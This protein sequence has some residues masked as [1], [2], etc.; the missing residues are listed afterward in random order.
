MPLVPKRV[1]AT[2]SSAWWA[3]RC[4]G[5][6]PDT[7]IVHAGSSSMLGTTPA[8][9]RSAWSASSATQASAA[10]SIQ[11]IDGGGPAGRCGRTDTTT[12]RVAPAGSAICRQPADDEHQPGAD[13]AAPQLLSQLRHVRGGIV[14]GHDDVDAE[15][16]QPL[17]DAR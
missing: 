6:S 16:A 17:D 9:R 12:A 15:V 3:R 8:A 2:V 13:P 5:S 11:R 1:S 10:P 7:V 14:P 4:A